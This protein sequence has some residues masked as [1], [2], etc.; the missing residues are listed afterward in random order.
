MSNSE[1]QTKGKKKKDRASR[2]GGTITNLA[3]VSLE[4]QK[5]RR[6]SNNGSNFSKFYKRLKPMD[7]RI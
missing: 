3:F 5:E 4:A 7:G 2:T 6:E 1:A